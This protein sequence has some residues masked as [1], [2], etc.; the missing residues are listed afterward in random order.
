MKRFT[1]LY[2]IRELI[3][4]GS[5]QLLY[6]GVIIILLGNNNSDVEVYK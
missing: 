3:C 4:G 1:K 6:A 2:L 5:G